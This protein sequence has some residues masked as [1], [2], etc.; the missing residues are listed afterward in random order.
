MNILIFILVYF[1]IGAISATIALLIQKKWFSDENEDLAILL[2]CLWP[3]AF[4][5]AFFFAIFIG[6]PKL[7][8][9]MVYKKWPPMDNGY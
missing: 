5:M 8:Y 1:G 3:L 6:I 4:P 2:F 9:F 7:I